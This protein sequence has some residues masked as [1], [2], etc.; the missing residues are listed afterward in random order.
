MP[1]PAITLRAAAAVPPIVLFEPLISIWMFAP[2]S[3]SVVP[4]ELVPMKLPAIVLPL[5]FPIG[6]IGPIRKLSP[7]RG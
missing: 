4:L 3:S 5:L 2:P 7:G 1:A 6:P